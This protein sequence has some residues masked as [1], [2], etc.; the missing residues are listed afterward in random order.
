MGQYLCCGIATGI[1]AK[2]VNIEGWKMLTKKQII[3][4]LNNQLNLD[5]YDIEEDEKNVYFSI[6]KDIFEENIIPFIK[7]QLLKVNSTSIKEDVEEI[8]KLE[9]KNYSELMNIAK[10]KSVIPFQYFEGYRVTNNVTYLSDYDFLCYADVISYLF[11]GKII[12]ESYG[13]L[14]DYL[15]KSIIQSSDNPIRDAAIVTMIG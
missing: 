6:K 13:D 8:S 11:D 9:G 4:K 12:I 3:D 14:F 15:R 5:I 7:E 2:K 1:T 10:E